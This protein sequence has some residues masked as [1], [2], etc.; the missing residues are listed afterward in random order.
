MTV[1]VIYDFAFEPITVSVIYVF[2][3]DLH[4]QDM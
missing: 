4:R 2:D 3:F 1:R